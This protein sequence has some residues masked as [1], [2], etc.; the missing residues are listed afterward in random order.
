MLGLYG[1]GGL[2]REVLDMLS[3]SNATADLD[4][5]FFIDDFAISGN[6]KNG[7]SS[8][9]LPE[10]MRMA[11]SESDKL[12][13]VICVG[14]PSSRKILRKK[15]EDENLE[16]LS[17]YSNFASVSTFA[18]VASGVLMC[19]GVT[20]AV[21]S[22]IGINTVIN[23]NSIVG[24]DVQIGNDCSISSQ[25]NIGGGSQIGHGT[26]LGMGSL[27]REGIK[28][29]DSSIIGMGSV[30]FDDIPSGVIAIGNP[31]RVVKRNDS[32]ISFRNGTT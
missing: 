21:G 30:V 17:V 24:H 1:A 5:I 26:Y 2:G 28:I 13:V 11:E 19:S 8:Y 29:G 14:S 15:I 4:S 23:V 20:A 9:K 12:R 18:S 25:V 6:S 32:G 3:A 31:A 22:Q 27:I 7:I 10:L 16:L